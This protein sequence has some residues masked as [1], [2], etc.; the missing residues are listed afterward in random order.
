MGKWFDTKS[1]WFLSNREY[2]YSDLLSEK[3]IKL[4]DEHLKKYFTSLFLQ[5][6]I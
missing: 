3:F 4:Y 1:D 5:S 2:L 6:L